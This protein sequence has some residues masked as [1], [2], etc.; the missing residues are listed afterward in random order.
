MKKIHTKTERFNSKLILVQPTVVE[1]KEYII[2]NFKDENLNDFEDILQESENKFWFGG[3][4]AIFNGDLVE[5]W[6]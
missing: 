1:A 4:C 2:E 6:K 3:N 5:I